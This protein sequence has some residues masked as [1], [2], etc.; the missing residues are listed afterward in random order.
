MSKRSSKMYKDS[1]TIGEDDEGKKVVKKGG[2]KETEAGKEAAKTD[3]GTI[4]I[5]E[6]DTL[7]LG[8]KHE[9]ERLDL[10]HKHEKEHHAMHQK[11]GKEGSPAE[12]K[13]ESKAEAKSEGDK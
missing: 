11:H 12:E 7:A 5:Q 3:D 8:Q 13:S 4:G 1:P 2:E 10:H 9:K 6:K